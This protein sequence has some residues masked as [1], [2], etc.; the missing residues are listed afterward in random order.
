M[1]IKLT[2][3]ETAK[4][5][6]LV[7]AKAEIYAQIKEMQHYAENFAVGVWQEQ[8]KLEA[9]YQVDFASGK[10]KLD[11]VNNTIEEEEPKSKIIAPGV[12]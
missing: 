12:N 3:E 5:K 9:K 11:L 2:T 8:K 10:W 6:D 1:A 7:M 4:L